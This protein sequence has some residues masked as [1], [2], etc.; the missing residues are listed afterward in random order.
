MN[1][2]S[3]GAM[4][5]IAVLIIVGVGLFDWDG[6][7]QTKQGVLASV[8]YMMSD[9]S[10]TLTFNDGVELTFKEDN[11]EDAQEMYDYLLAWVGQEIIIEYTYEFWN[12]EYFLN[13]VNPVT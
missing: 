8:E 1:K 10:Y 2:N 12:A 11:A 6:E 5:V 7:T 3:L 4:A 13:S 9:T